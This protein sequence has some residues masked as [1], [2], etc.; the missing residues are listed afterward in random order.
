[1]SSNEDSFDLVACLNKL[2]QNLGIPLEIEAP[3]ELTPSLLIAMLECLLRRRLPLA[4]TLRGARDLHS[5]TQA[6]V[7]FLEELEDE[8]LDYDAGCGDVD[9]ARLAFGEWDEVVFVGQ[10]LCWLGSTRQVLPWHISTCPTFHPNESINASIVRRNWENDDS[11]VQSAPPS[12][13]PPPDAFARRPMT[14]SFDVSQEPSIVEEDMNMTSIMPQTPP[15]SQL[16]QQLPESPDFFAP[17]MTAQPRPRPSLS[18]SSHQSSS[19][20]QS[21]RCIHEVGQ[22]FSQDASSFSRD[23]SGNSLSEASISLCKCPSALNISSTM[24]DRSSARRPKSARSSSSG[25]VPT[26]PDPAYLN[27]RPQS[28]SQA[29]RSIKSRYIG[30]SVADGTPPPRTAR[31]Q[32]VIT[33]HNSPTE[34]TLALLNERAKLLDGLTRLGI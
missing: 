5:K 30:L 23:D 13:L 17:R 7:V 20:T 22:S 11:G 26:T 18:R 15:R 2:I 1:M 21:A 9:P 6:M 24:T 32:R 14:S 28:T 25:S 31:G 33:R 16:S 34:H 12:P 29:P 4:Q 19:R 10:V 3:Y 8:T 27:F